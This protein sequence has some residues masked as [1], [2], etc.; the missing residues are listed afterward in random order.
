[1]LR[2]PAASLPEPPPQI[3]VF[4]WRGGIAMTYGGD[5][6]DRSRLERDIALL[7]TFA[8]GLDAVPARNPDTL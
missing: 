6:L 1:M 7:D 3:L 4:D 5:P 8:Q 2:Y